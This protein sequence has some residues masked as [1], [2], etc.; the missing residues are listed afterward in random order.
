MD[1]LF[2]KS[3]RFWKLV[4]CGVAAAMFSMGLISEMM[5]TLVQ[6]VLMGSVVIRTIDRLGEKVGGK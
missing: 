1:L 5:N 2:L 4:L 3:N 6:S